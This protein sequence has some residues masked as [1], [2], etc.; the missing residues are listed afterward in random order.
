MA[1]VLWLLLILQFLSSR[2][3]EVISI[4]AT[5]A[6]YTERKMKVEM[7]QKSKT[8]PGVDSFNQLMFYKKKTASF[9]L[10][11]FTAE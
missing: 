1:V 4:R 6:K 7:L 11:T 5:C 10:W 9:A 2:G 3:R 8:F